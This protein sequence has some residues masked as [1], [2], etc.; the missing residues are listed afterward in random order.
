MR[1]LSRLL[2]IKRGG[3]F[4]RPGL[5]IAMMIFSAAVGAET[6]APAAK[7]VAGKDA[8]AAPP[9]N[10]PPDA[11][12][13][14]A[15]QDELTRRLPATEIQLLDVD[16]GKVVGLYTE[17]TAKKVR[18]AVLLLPGMDRSADDPG[19]VQA[20]REALPKAGWSTLSLQLPLLPAGSPREAYGGVVE[21]ARKRIQAALAQLGKLQQK[22][23]VI[24]G[25][26]LGGALALLS[27]PDGKKDV[28]GVVALSLD[29]VDGLN[30]PSIRRR[31]STS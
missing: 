8:K 14:Q 7:P 30:P 5:L 2:A 18:G 4:G 15:V 13:E 23:I 1:T 17:Q 29:F 6:P 22:N 25:L 10:I 9:L 27:A 12:R 16:K 24:V 11:A 3:G 20:L 28:K 19:L 21:A 26:D 31:V